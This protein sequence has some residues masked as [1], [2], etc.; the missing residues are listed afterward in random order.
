MIKRKKT[1]SFISAKVLT[2]FQIAFCYWKV[3]WHR[4]TAHLT[5]GYKYSI[6]YCHQNIRTKHGQQ[7]Q[8]CQLERVYV[9]QRVLY[10]S[11]FGKSSSCLALDGKFVPSAVWMGDLQRNRHSLPVV[12]YHSTYNSN[13][14]NTTQNKRIYRIGRKT[15]KFGTA[16]IIGI[17]I[18]CVPIQTNITTLVKLSC[19]HTVSSNKQM[20]IRIL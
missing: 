4:K 17:A 10:Y 20:A 11:S 9:I 1:H 18:D 13:D 12:C 5:F 7:K 14:R 16:C 8:S 3:C 15:C 2:A 6:D 19:R